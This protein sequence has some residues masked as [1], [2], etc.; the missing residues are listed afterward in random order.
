MK[1]TNIKNFRF[2]DIRRT[3]GT[4]LLENGV[5]IRT[6]QS[7]LGHSNIRVTERYLALTPSQNAKAMKYLDLFIN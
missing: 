7:L 1:K 2:H 4:W 6:I 5:D 3:V